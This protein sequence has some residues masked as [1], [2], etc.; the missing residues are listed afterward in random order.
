MKKFSVRG[1]KQTDLSIVNY[2]DG[3]YVVKVG[4]GDLINATKVMVA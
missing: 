1:D 4:N 3:L 2:A